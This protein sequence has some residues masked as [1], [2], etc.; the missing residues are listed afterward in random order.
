MGTGGFAR[1]CALV[2]LLHAAVAAPGAR[3]GA[4]HLHDCV[5]NLTTDAFS[6]DAALAGSPTTCRD[7]DTS[8]FYRP[9]L[10]TGGEH[11]HDGAVR[12]P[13]SVRM[14]DFPSRRD[15][16]G[17]D[18]PDRRAHL[19][20]PATN[21]ARPA[22]TFPVP[23]LRVELGHELPPGTRFTVDGFADLAEPAAAD[24]AHRINARTTAAAAAVVD[25]LDSGRR[26]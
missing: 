13:D 8:T 26:C 18:S 19:V 24:H 22:A 23:A 7:G 1:A 14:L 3:D 6:T 9:V 10:R 25:C 5:G 4:R 16:R 17:T 15:G 2:A 11:G 12:T 21:G 20:F